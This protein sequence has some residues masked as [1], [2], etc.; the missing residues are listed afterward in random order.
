MSSKPGNQQTWLRLYNLGCCVWVARPGEKV[1]ARG[2]SIAQ[3]VKEACMR[4]WAGEVAAL[5]AEATGKAKVDRR[6][7]RRMPQTRANSTL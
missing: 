4:W 7:R 3:Q 5:W 1:S 2:R 6:V